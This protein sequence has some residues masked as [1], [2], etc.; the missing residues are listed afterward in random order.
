MLSQ[1]KSFFR[2]CQNR[3][4]TS[5][6]FRIFEVEAGGTQASRQDALALEDGGPS[7]F[8][9]SQSQGKS[10][11]AQQ[12]RAVKGAAQRTGELQIGNRVGRD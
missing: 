6:Q 8:A 11:D 5:F 7:H 3:T 10:R 12:R 4:Q 1:R 2:R 9:E